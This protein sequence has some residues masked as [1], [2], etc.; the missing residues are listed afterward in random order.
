MRNPFERTAFLDNWVRTHAI[1]FI[2]IAKDFSKFGRGDASDH[3]PERGP[4]QQLWREVENDALRGIILWSQHVLYLWEDRV[5]HLSP[6]DRDMVLLIEWLLG[7][8]ES[9]PAIVGLSELNWELP[10]RDNNPCNRDFLAWR[11]RT[12]WPEWCKKW[13]EL[14][15]YAVD[16]LEA[17]ETRAPPAQLP[18]GMKDLSITSVA[19]FIKISRKTLIRHMDKAGVV[20][21]GDGDRSLRFTKQKAAVTATA[22]ADSRECSKEHK[23]Q[24]HELMVFFGD[25]SFDFNVPT[26]ATTRHRTS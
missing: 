14:A 26:K 25:S 19:K 13:T 24:W 3:L 9:D 12:M 23:I 5:R 8:K 11:L 7:N 6:R 22:H 4:Y 1:E 15:E 20:R 17:S 16:S 18:D 21:K 2:E 10:T